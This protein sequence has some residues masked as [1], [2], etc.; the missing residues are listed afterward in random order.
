MVENTETPDPNTPAEE[1]KRCDVGAGCVP[2]WAIWVIVILA[3]T[4]TVLDLYGLWA[5]WPD[6][7]TT[8]SVNL[9]VFTHGFT[10]TA[11]QQMLALVALAG[12]L[13]GLVHFLRSF[14]RYVGNRQLLWSWVTHYALIPVTAAAA[15]TIFYIVTRA[16]LLATNPPAQQGGTSAVAS[17]NPFGF[18]AVGALVGLFTEEAMQMLKKTAKTIFSEPEKAQ[19]PLKPPPADSNNA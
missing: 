19:D 1:P 15:S 4:A 17:I 5:I 10:A 14:G 12:A 8:K 18:A 16:G 11:E 3:V 9:V 13:G 6:P 7:T 2:A